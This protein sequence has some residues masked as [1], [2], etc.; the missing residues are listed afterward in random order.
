MMGKTDTGSVLNITKISRKG[1]STYT[2]IPEISQSKTARF[3][4]VKVKTV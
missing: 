3:G 1:G 4:W 2:Y